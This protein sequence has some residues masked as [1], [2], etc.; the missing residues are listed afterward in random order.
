LTS[1][2]TPDLSVLLFLRPLF[3]YLVSRGPEVCREGH[4][5]RWMFV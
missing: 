5:S 4:G 2:K 3:V 1:G